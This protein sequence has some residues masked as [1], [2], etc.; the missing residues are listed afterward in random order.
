MRAPEARWLN[1]WK[2]LRDTLSGKGKHYGELDLPLV[3]AVNSTTF[4]LD[5]IDVMQALFGQEEYIVDLDDREE[6]PI[7][8]RRRNG[9][10]LGPAGKQYRRISAVLIGYD[11]KP[12]TFG[13][14]SLTLYKNP[15]ASRSV[16]GALDAFPLYKLQDNKMELLAGMKL[17]SV[18]DLPRYYP[19]M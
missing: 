2:R 3:I 1:T 9:L 16:Q 5:N 6:E 15:W 8:R 7:M 14:R 10:W 4:H 11:V 18:L 17:Q 19:G 13:V 12:W